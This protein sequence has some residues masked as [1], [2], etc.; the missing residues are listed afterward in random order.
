MALGYIRREVGVPGREVTIGTAQAT[1]AAIPFED[2]ALL[3]EDSLAQHR[4]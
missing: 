1:V 3:S 4:A 2:I